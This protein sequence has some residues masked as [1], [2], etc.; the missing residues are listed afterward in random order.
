MSADS[1]SIFKNAHTLHVIPTAVGNHLFIATCALVQQLIHPRR[2]CGLQT[3]IPQPTRR[4]PSYAAPKGV[5]FFAVDEK[6]RTK[7]LLIHQN[8]VVVVV[9]GATVSGFPCFSVNSMCA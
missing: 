6:G 2:R 8:Q 7:L 3:H 5:V 1:M 9:V 4:S